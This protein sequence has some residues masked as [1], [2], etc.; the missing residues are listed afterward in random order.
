MAYLPFSLD[1]HDAPDIA[2][3]AINNQL[4][5]EVVA[6]F[7]KSYVNKSANKV[8]IERENSLKRA[9]EFAEPAEAQN[10]ELEDDLQ[11]IEDA[12]L[13]EHQ[14]LRAHFDVQAQEE[15]PE[16]KRLTTMKNDRYFKIT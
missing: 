12:M 1:N 3:S 8:L 16:E 10:N 13:R 11:L 7:K 4:Y 6:I 9:N 15:Q 14:V 2:K 5:E